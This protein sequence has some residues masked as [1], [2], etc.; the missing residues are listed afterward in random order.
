[1]GYTQTL[2]YSH[3]CEHG[4]PML[5]ETLSFMHAQ[6]VVEARMGA[7]PAA[8]PIRSPDAV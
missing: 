2:E 4:N 3:Y 6:Y 8:V 1:M 7:H 5:R